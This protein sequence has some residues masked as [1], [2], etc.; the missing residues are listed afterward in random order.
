MKEMM[1]LLSMIQEDAA[2]LSTGDLRAEI[3]VHVEL[4]SKYIEEFQNLQP[5]AGSA[6]ELIS[7]TDTLLVGALATALYVRELTT[8]PAEERRFARVR[9]SFN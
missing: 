3:Q 4:F 7:A 9:L 1:A 2:A 5:G 6:E 8:R